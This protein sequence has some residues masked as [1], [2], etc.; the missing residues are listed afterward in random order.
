L[1]LLP[2]DRF[3]LLLVIPSSGAPVLAMLAGVAGIELSMV[4]A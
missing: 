4:D 2:G 1:A 3:L